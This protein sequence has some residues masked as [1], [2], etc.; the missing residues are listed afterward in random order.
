[1]EWE[2]CV[3]KAG[4]ECGLEL[5]M[6]HPEVDYD[7]GAFPWKEPDWE[8]QNQAP[9]GHEGYQEGYEGQEGYYEGQESYENQE[10]Y[11]EQ[12]EGAEGEEYYE[13]GPGGEQQQYPEEVEERGL[14]QLA[15]SSQSEEELVQQVQALGPQ[16]GAVVEALLAPAEEVKA[17]EST[18]VKTNE[19]PIKPTE[20][21]QQ[22]PILQESTYVESASA[23]PEDNKPTPPEELAPVTIPGLASLSTMESFQLP[24][25]NAA[26]NTAAVVPEV[27][28]VEKVETPVVEP[29]KTPVVEIKPTP[30][31]VKAP[32]VAPIVLPKL[33]ATLPGKTP[34]AVMRELA[35][36]VS[37]KRPSPP[38]ESIAREVKKVKTEEAVSAPPPAKSAPPPVVPPPAEDFNG[39]EGDAN[40]VIPPPQDYNSDEEKLRAAEK[41]LKAMKELEAE[42]TAK[43]RKEQPKNPLKTPNVAL[44]KAA[45]SKAVS[46]QANP[47]RTIPQLP[48][49]TQLN[50]RGNPFER[51][52]PPMRQGVR[53]TYPPQNNPFAGN[54][55]E[56]VPFMSQPRERSR[57][58][59]PPAYHGNQAGNYNQ[60]GLYQ[61]FNGENH[62]RNHSKGRG[63]GGSY[64]YA[65][66][67]DQNGY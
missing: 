50:Q 46:K 22:S 10:Y 3:I 26:K 57:D 6:F 37:L 19:S 51:S 47:L 42:E 48:P 64:Q 5:V 62:G 27:K 35:K 20:S 59:H 21:A 49:Q 7:S 33:P 2:E 67:Q 60:G 14:S 4:K 41:K 11:E 23:T 39:F 63:K 12:Q 32:P 17:V 31:T 45:M 43:L 30:V 56:A 54:P 15:D 13:E 1:M 61:Q 44:S 28:P 52:A 40:M 25:Q 65:W 55:F 9:E 18:P 38:R 24:E 29:V 58:P 16:I 36:T 66:Q 34:A 53:K 8:A